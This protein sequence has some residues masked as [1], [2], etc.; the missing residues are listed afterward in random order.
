MTGRTGF[1]HAEHTE[2]IR[3][4]LCP[5]ILQ[6]GFFERARLRQSGIVHQQI[7]APG[8]PQDRLYACLNGCLRTDVQREQFKA[9]SL[10]VQ[11]RATGAKHKEALGCQQGC[12]SLA[13]AR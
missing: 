6:A 10:V 3:F 9:G 13:E 7:D 11:R 1:Q 12:G 5:C 2:D 4:K 8:A